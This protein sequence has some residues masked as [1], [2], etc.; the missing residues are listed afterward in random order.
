MRCLCHHRHF[1]PRK[2]LI[3][4]LLK[5]AEQKFDIYKSYPHQESVASL[6]AADRAKI[7]KL[8]FRLLG[9][10]LHGTLTL[11]HSVSNNNDNI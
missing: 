3:I 9:F 2:T 1:P 4:P 7:A 5:T 6:N 10:F 8:L 11:Q